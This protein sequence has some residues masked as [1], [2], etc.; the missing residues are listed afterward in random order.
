M[1]TVMNILVAL[2][3]MYYVGRIE[4]SYKHKVI[5]KYWIFLPWENRK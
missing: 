2:M 3:L 1:N 4:I 5:K